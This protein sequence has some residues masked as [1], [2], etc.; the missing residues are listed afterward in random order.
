MV[1]DSSHRSG[2][3]FLNVLAVLGCL[4][5]A[6]PPALAREQVKK[7]KGP[8]EAWLNAQDVCVFRFPSKRFPLNAEKFDYALT[9]GYARSL[10]LP[11]LYGTVVLDA[12]RYP[13]VDALRINLSD[14]RVDQNAKAP[15]LRPTDRRL[16]G[17]AVHVKQF[18]LVSRPLNAGKAKINFEVAASDVRLDFG[19]DKDNKRVLLMTDAK[20]GTFS[21]E[22]SH[23]DMET[24]LLD[25][26]KKAARKH[27]LR[28]RQV[29]LK[30]D[31]AEDGSVKV[32]MRVFSLVGGLV[33]AGLRFKARLD[34]DENL[35]GRLSGLSCTGDNILGPLISGLIRPGL[36]KHNGLTRPLVRFPLDTIKLHD[37]KISS[38]ETVRLSATFGR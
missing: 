22:I 8:D 10:F 23:K 14:A 35:N 25:G 33:P 24:M 16:S 19:K 4:A 30:L 28:V 21:V 38:G 27:G 20:E 37:V 18:E 11:D 2:R 9:R 5:L 29:R 1:F 34:I 12:A 36:K 3:S 13:E 26:A 7:K 6:A 17:R 32:E 31:A 15:P